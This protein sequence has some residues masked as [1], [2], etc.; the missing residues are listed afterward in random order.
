VTVAVNVPLSWGHGAWFDNLIFGLMPLI[1]ATLGALI[2]TRLPDNAIG[3]IFCVQGFWDGL[4]QMWGEGMDYHHAPTAAV[5]HWVTLWG[6][7]L[8][9]GAYGMVLLLFPAGRFLSRRWRSSAWLLAAGVVISAVT[10]ALTARDRGNPWHVNSSGLDS[11]V[12][13][14][15]GLLVAAFVTAAASI[16]VRYR[17]AVGPERLQVRV[18]MFAAAVMIPSWAL[19]VPFY[20]RSSLVQAW[21]HLSYLVIPLAVGL[22]VLRYRLYDI[23][24]VINRTLVYT[25]LTATLAAVYLSSVLLLQ[26]VLN[27]FTEGSSLA[28]A[29]STLAVAAAFRPAR[30]RIQDLVDRR[31]FRNKYNAAQT[32]DRF[33][34]HLRDQVDL[35]GIGDD[36]LRVVDKTVQPA[37]ASLWLRTQ[38]TAR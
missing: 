3:W 17:R 11:I 30:S 21:D 8:D 35:A 4:S 32:L 38:E 26:V 6:W 1:L 27:P 14:G 19:A 25:A 33:S 37:H 9:V 15:M 22:A 18:L 16:V 23:D 24:V 28:I 5:G 12:R 13:V 10:Q 7:V 20:Y 29:A 36:L 34:T 31:F 2:A